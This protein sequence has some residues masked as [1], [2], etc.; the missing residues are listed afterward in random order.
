[1][2]AKIVLLPG[3][4]IGPEVVAQAERVLR[5]ATR[6]KNKILTRIQSMVAGAGQV[7]LRDGEYR[8]INTSLLDSIESHLLLLFIGHRQ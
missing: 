2:N 8:K 1:M 3:D 4:G 5:G 6:L 7:S